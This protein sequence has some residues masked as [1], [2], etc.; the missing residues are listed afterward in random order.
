MK[1]ILS[2]CLAIA[3]LL[4]AI[5]MA[6][7]LAISQYG[8]VTG[9]WLRLRSAASFDSSTVSSYYTG[10]QVKILSTSGSWYQVEA[11][12]GKTGYMYSSYISFSGGI[13][14]DAYVTSTNGYGVRMRSGPGTGYSIIGVYSVG[15]ALTVLQ[16]G[17]TWSKIQ[18]GSRVGYMMNQYITT[19][20]GGGT[21]GDTAT[22]WSANGYGV[23]LRSGAGTGYSIIG[24]YSVGTLVTVLSH[25]TTWDHISVGSRTGYMMN[26]F[27][28][29][30]SSKTVT[31]V[32]LNN[33][34]PVVGSVLSV[35]TLTPSGATVSYEWYVGTDIVANTATYTVLSTDLGQ[36]IKL[37]VTGTGDYSGSATS[38][39][40]S[41][42]VA[43]QE[44]TGGVLNND[45]PVVGDVL[46]VIDIV[47]SN[48][49]V[50][51]QW[52][53]GGTLVGT[54]SSYTVASTDVYQSVSV[55]ITGSGLYTGSYTINAAT[56]VQA[57]GAV[58]G[59][60]IVN[61]TNDTVTGNTIPN[62]SDVLI[63]YP[64]PATATVT[65]KWQ[66]ADDDTSLLGTTSQLAV[67]SAMVDRTLKVTITGTGNYAG[68]TGGPTTI[69][70]VVNLAKITEVKFRSADYAPKLDTDATENSIVATVWTTS[71]DVTSQC[72]ITWYRGDTLTSTTGDTYSLTTADTG[73]V[74]TAKAV[75]NGTTVAG[76]KSR[77][78]TSVVKQRIISV[79][80]E[81]TLGAPS[82]HVMVGDKL[83]AV[84][85]GGDIES[86]NLNATYAWKLIGIT[87]N[88]LEYTVPAT[89]TVGQTLVLTITAKGNYYIDGTVSTSAIVDAT[90]MTVT[91]P[92]DAPVAGTTYTVTAAPEAATATYVWK[93][94]GTTVSSGTS[95]SV[96]VA[97]AYIGKVMT[98]YVTPHDGY[99]ISDADKEQDTAAVVRQDFT[100]KLYGDFSVGGTLTVV[101]TPSAATVES[102]EWWVVG[103][104]RIATTT[105]KSYKIT[106][107]D[108]SGAS[109]YV[110]V[111]GNG[112]YTGCVVSTLSD[113]QP[114]SAVSSTESIIALPADYVAPIEET[115]LDTSEQTLTDETP[116][117][118]EPT[119]TDAAPVTTEPTV[120]DETP[121]TT[122]PTVTD[123]TVTPADVD[124][125]AE[126]TQTAIYT[127]WFAN[128]PADVIANTRIAVL[129]SDTT[130]VVSYAWYR[131]EVLLIDEISG[132]YVVTQDDID[133]N[134]QLTVIVTFSDGQQATA[135]IKLGTS[136]IS[137]DSQTDDTLPV[138]PLLGE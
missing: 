120:T 53:I 45:S 100:V 86:T 37:K 71:G 15:T 109:I 82:G 80:I 61:S 92:T 11:P 72:D 88:T 30:Y 9:G 76:T 63:A 81:D 117:T 8:Y 49:T 13:I 26:E 112:N 18:I 119:V 32:T 38:S 60:E 75:G 52:Y 130:A 107:P 56:T 16:T 135:S 85:N 84:L 64:V 36:Q 41:A 28:R 7:S 10:T 57:T 131:G 1:R 70:P 27:L 58:T 67:T 106:D 19:S 95:K 22:V 97:S 101:T 118:T 78:T 115:S 126:E 136:T 24:V 62:V 5:P 110:I 14:G 51:Y 133:A 91:L 23:R 137:T 98:L 68:S 102:V 21:S 44:I 34:T 35:N 127:A 114:I 40:T 25:G 125:V 66:Y 122:E 124:P 33:T 4:T 42:V 46:K 50:S 132:S 94:D 48:A 31:A 3:L 43:G 99:T 2:I 90:T 116:V 103:G 17:S 89:G 108:L 6:T 29:Y 104:S 87:T 74:I 128:A 129:T 93:V 105:S 79:A 111:T 83:T 65:Y 20:G 59:V 55:T 73:Y 123:G 47:P 134:S 113:P 77:S 121:V 39:L 54:K 138:Q 69:G 96:S 12:D